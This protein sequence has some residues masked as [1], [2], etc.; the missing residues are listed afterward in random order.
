MT[1][2]ERENV[3]KERGH[4]C[5]VSKCERGVYHMKNGYCIKHDYRYKMFGSPTQITRSDPNSYTIKDGVVTINL[6]DK[7]GNIIAQALCD[8][9]DIEIVKKHKWCK[10]TRNYVQTTLKSNRKAVHMHRMI[11]GDSFSQIDHIN[12]NPLDN[13]RA[14]LRACNDFQNNRNRRTNGKNKYR[15]VHNSKSGKNP[16]IVRLWYQGDNINVGLF[17]DER[18]AAHIYNSCMEQLLGEST[19]FFIPNKI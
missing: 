9:T 17:N 11:M 8:E 18:E 16:Y 15:G 10:S 5:S 7:S 1:A 14:N 12:R 4:I 19:E 13:R 6:Y 3:R 2:I